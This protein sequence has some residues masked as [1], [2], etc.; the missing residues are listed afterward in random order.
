M[1]TFTFHAVAMTVEVY[2]QGLQGQAKPSG[3][4]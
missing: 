2:K 4:I 1:V 3:L